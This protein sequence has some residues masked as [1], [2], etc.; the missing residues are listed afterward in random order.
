[1]IQ[2]TAQYATGFPLLSENNYNV[3]GF[4]SL[5]NEPDRSLFFIFI[6]YWSY[7]KPD[8]GIVC[9]G[10]LLFYTKTQTFFTDIVWSRVDRYALTDSLGQWCAKPNLTPKCVYLDAAIPNYFTRNILCLVYNYFHSVLN[11]RWPRS[12]ISWPPGRALGFF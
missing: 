2:L 1:M 12:K 8:D 7:W 6:S 11:C 5:D 9:K 10:I 3:Y 4:F